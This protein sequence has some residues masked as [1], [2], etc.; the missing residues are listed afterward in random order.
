MEEQPEPSA[1][2]CP[3][4]GGKP[5]HDPKH[6]LSASGYTHDDIHYTCSECSEEWTCG[7]P[8]GEHDNELAEDLY[9]QSCETRFG[10]VHRVQPISNTQVQFHM[11]CPNTECRNFWQIKRGSDDGVIL[12]GYP[13][14]TGSIEDATTEF[15]HP[16]TIRHTQRD[17]DDDE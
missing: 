9:C 11:K 2:N 5:E 8:I 14:I 7:V 10:L 13:Q 3:Y 4:C 15:G 12:M 16:N 17:L 1:S 6:V